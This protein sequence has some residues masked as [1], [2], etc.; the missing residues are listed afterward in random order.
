MLQDWILMTYQNKQIIQFH[1]SN[2]CHFVN[3]RNKIQ[4][5]L[6]KYRSKKRK[7]EFSTHT[8]AKAITGILFC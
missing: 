5:L 8:T 6:K 3:Q 1:L 7:N 2:M 4:P